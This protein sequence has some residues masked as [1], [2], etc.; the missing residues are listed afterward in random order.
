MLSIYGTEQTR[1]ASLLDAQYLWDRTDTCCFPAWCSVFMGQNRH[2]L[3]PC[4]MLSIY[5]TEQTL[6]AS[7]LDAQYLWDRTD[8]C[9]FPTWCS[10]FMGQNRSGYTWSQY[11]MSVWDIHTYT[12]QINLLKMK[13]NPFVNYQVSKWSVSTIYEIFHVKIHTWKFN[14]GINSKHDYIHRDILFV[15]GSAIK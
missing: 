12:W 15:A 8:T 13:L 10:V 11:N 3:L 9:C 14:F 6:V 2:L 4:L 1:V 5:G 7:L